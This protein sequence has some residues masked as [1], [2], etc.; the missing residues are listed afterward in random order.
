MPKVK[1]A[2]A[3]L[4]SDQVKEFKS[5]GSIEVAG[6]T[7]SAG[8][9]SVSASV[10]FSSSKDFHGGQGDTN[11]SKEDGE[12]IVV[13]DVR[14]SPEL[15]TM[16]LARGF[17]SSV[18]QLRKKAGLVATDDVDVFFKGASEQMKTAIE[19]NADAIWRDTKS[20]AVEASQMGDGA[21][22]IL[23]EEVEVAD[24]KVFVSL[25]SRSTKQ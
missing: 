22:V 18:Q 4:S 1:A 6:Q 2:L 23:E 3:E 19:G 12:L 17:I 24:Q 21:K 8:D 16:G 13:L 25:V 20:A 7:L 15:V 14:S 10:D 5:S 11:T 9:L